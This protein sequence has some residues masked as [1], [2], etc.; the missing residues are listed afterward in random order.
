MKIGLVILAAGYSERMGVL[1][2]LLPVGGE[3]A[4]KRA[5]G[6]GKHEKVHSITVVTG[7]RCEDIE[8]ELESI[9]AKNIR[10]V[11]NR[12]FDEGMLTS[13]K[14]GIHSLPTDLD[15]FFLLPVDHCAVNPDTLEKLIAAFIL[16]KG[17][18]VVTPVCDGRRG[19]PPLIPYV[20]AA[21]L[22]AYDGDDGMRGY[23]S[24]FP[25]TEIEVID[26][27]S[28]LDMDTPA[29]YEA[30][31]RHLGLPTY[32]GEDVCRQLMDKYGVPENVRAHCRAVNSVALRAARLLDKKGVAVNAGL[33]TSACLLHDIVRLQPEHENGGAKVLLSE[34]YPATAQL[35]ARHM[36]LPDG[37]EPKPDALALLYLADKLCRSE[38]VVPIDKTLETLTSRFSDNPEALSGAEKRLARAREILAMLTEKYGI[39][40]QDIAQ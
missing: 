17:E 31:L 3:T 29:D 2:P 4:L 37:Y 11:Y 8:A 21:G 16:E 27:G 34:G 18:A 38:T 5:V 28:V 19:H 12:H 35:V 40:Y 32:P 22:K 1:K 7:Y 20:F 13:V 6:L 33:L 39:T 24:R 25:D 26:E 30:L 10:H 36:D 23:L 15:G 14:A 9:H